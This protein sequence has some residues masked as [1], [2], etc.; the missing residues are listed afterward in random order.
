MD[1][2]S[3]IVGFLILQSLLPE[4]L[5]VPWRLLLFWTRDKR[6]ASGKARSG[7]QAASVCIGF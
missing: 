3:V 2:S 1:S 6:V 4:G 5:Q 7:E